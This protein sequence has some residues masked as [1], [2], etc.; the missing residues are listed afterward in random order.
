[1][2][3]NKERLSFIIPI[4]LIDEKTKLSFKAVILDVSSKGLRIFSNDK[5]LLLANES[6]LKE[7]I[8]ELEFDFFD[9]PTNGLKAKVANISPGEN[10]E[11]ERRLGLAFVDVP[12][13]QT[14]KIEEFLQEFRR[15]E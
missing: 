2:E 12:P 4:L 11:F 3:R 14:R 7:K 9:V 13:E 1:M 10:S 15:K 5:R 6:V 8:F